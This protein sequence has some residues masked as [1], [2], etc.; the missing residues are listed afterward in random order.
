LQDVDYQIVSEKIIQY[1]A[2]PKKGPTIDVVKYIII[3]E[4]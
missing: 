1:Q 2:V 3:V 4:V